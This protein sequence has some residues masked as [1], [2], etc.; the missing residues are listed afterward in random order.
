MERL[1]LIKSKI[2]TWEHLKQKLAVWRY[3]EKTIVFSNGCFDV[4]HLGHVEYLAKARDLGD[5]LIVGLNSDDSVHRIKGARR[6]V[7]NEEARAVTLAAFSFVDGVILFGE[8]TPHELIKLIQPDILVKGKDYEGKEIV[9]SDVV[10]AHGGQVVTI[11][12]TKGYSTTHTI[13][14]AQKVHL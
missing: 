8:D 11:E 10:K 4:L 14:L 13:E 2:F 3:K 12:L 1:S 7:N 6:P 9:G 5:I